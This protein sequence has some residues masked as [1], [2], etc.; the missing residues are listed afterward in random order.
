[1]RNVFDRLNVRKSSKGEM[2]MLWMQG[3]KNRGV[4]GG[5]ERNAGISEEE[6]VVRKRVGEREEKEINGRKLREGHEWKK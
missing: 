4:G 5:R 2:K 1:M 3:T 6:E